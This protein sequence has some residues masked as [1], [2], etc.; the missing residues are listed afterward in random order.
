MIAPARTFY[1]DLAISQVSARKFELAGKIS[2]HGLMLQARLVAWSSLPHFS[3]SPTF[4][5]GHS[6]ATTIAGPAAH[7]ARASA[8]ILG[9]QRQMRRAQASQFFSP[10]SSYF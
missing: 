9:S 6:N 4:G 2:C 8:G 3:R 10:Y 1:C 7:K 5:A